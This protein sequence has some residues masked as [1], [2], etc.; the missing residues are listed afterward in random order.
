M[1]YEHADYELE[2]LE[3]YYIIIFIYPKTPYILVSQKVEMEQGI[4]CALA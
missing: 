2:D 4:E 1:N 3:V